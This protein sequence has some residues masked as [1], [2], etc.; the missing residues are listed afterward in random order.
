MSKCHASVRVRVCTHTYTTYA[1]II[2]IRHTQWLYIFLQS[3]NSVCSSVHTLM[4]WKVE[5]KSMSVA[6]LVMHQQ[7]VREMHHNKALASQCSY[8]AP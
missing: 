7:L 3:L 5:H 6:V 1:Y 8:T 4:K 2:I